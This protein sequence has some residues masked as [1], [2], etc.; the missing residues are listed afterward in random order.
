MDFS[1]YFQGSNFEGS[2]IGLLSLDA[3]CSWMDENQPWVDELHFGGK[4]HHHLVLDFC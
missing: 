2:Q 1:A 3:V 4:I